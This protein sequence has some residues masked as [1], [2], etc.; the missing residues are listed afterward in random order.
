MR[1]SILA[2]LSM[3]L[4]PVPNAFAQMSQYQFW[5]KQDIVCSVPNYEG[6]GDLE[7]QWAF[8]QYSNTG[9]GL[10]YTVHSSSS[11]DIASIYLSVHEK[12]LI[13]LRQ[14]KSTV[15]RIVKPEYTIYKPP[16][17]GI[18]DYRLIRITEHYP[19]TGSFSKESIFLAQIPDISK[20]QPPVEDMLTEVKFVPPQQT[21]A[22]LLG[23]GQGVWKGEVNTFE[24]EALKF[25]FFVWNSGDANCCPSGGTVRG[26]YKVTKRVVDRVE[27]FNERGQR[28]S[29]DVT[30]YTIEMDGYQWDASG[31]SE[32]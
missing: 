4:L 3:L 7:L 24:E 26:T 23:E 5:S 1:T 9:I 32:R 18:S 21:F 25:R 16:G 15:G 17:E 27:R 2:L 13:L 29:R 11:G 8:P 22:P 20:W 6:V 31:G 14:V 28:Y 30:E 19:G 10:Y 12:G